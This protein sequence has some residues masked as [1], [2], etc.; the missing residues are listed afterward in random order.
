MIIFLHQHHYINY[1]IIIQNSLYLLFD[2]SCLF[3]LHF[4]KNTGNFVPPDEYVI[5]RLKLSNGAFLEIQS[6]VGFPG[7]SDAVEELHITA[8]GCLQQTS[9]VGVCLKPTSGWLLIF[10]V[11]GYVYSSDCEAHAFLRVS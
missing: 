8:G 7:T 2:C 6:V 11:F 1:F 10:V 3:A 4:E 5:G 9:D